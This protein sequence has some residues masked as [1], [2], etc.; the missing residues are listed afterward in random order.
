[1]TLLLFFLLLFFS[2]R[3]YVSYKRLGSLLWVLAAQAKPSCTLH[4]S[5]FFIM[6]IDGHSLQ[7]I[8]THRHKSTPKLTGKLIC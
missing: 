4:Y 2:K 5:I 1:M 6:F 8:I 3:V 7:V